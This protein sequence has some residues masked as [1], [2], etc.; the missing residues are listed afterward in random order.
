MALIT[1]RSV[2]DAVMER[3]AGGPMTVFLS[4]GG[5]PPVCPSVVVHPLAARY[6]GTV[7]DHT[8]D[9]EVEFQTTCIGSTSEQAVWAH[10]KIATRLWRTALSVAPGVVTLPLWAIPGTQQPVR[11]DDALATPVYYLTCSWMAH[12]I[13]T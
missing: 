8:R 7:G 11:R 12:A 6:T 3:I 4:N 13:P 2:I 10:D 1:T 5:T 9:A